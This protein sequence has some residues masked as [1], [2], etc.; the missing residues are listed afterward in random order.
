MS[1]SV[2]GVYTTAQAFSG[3]ELQVYMQKMTRL[4]NMPTLFAGEFSLERPQTLGQETWPQE[5][6]NS[7]QFF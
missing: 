4:V 3:G 5:N 7:R 2:V 1:S 6:S